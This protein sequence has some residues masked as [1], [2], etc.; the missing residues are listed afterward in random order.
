MTDAINALIGERVRF[1]RTSKGITLD[2]MAASFSVPISGQQLA[3]YEVGKSRWPADL[4][5]EIA[6]DLRLD[7]RLLTGLEDGK[8]EGKDDAEWDAERYKSI[9]LS[10]NE[11]ARKVVYKIIDGIKTL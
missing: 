6:K 11:K 2:K 4:L 7:I 10:L 3:K 9:I 5:I 1:Y 8:H